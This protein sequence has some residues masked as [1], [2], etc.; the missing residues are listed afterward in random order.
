MVVELAS[1]IKDAKADTK[2]LSRE[3]KI[4]L[5]KNAEY[6]EVLMHKLEQDNEKLAEKNVVLKLEEN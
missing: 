2:E 6:L 4:Q 5:T 3:I 1:L